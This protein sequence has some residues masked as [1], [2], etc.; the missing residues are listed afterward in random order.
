MVDSATNICC[1]YPIVT[2]KLE[3]NTIYWK[4]VGEQCFVAIYLLIVQYQ[5][6]KSSSTIVSVPMAIDLSRSVADDKKT[7]DV[8][9]EHMSKDTTL[10]KRFLSLCQFC[11]TVAI[12]LTH[13]HHA[14]IFHIALSVNQG[15]LQ[16][17]LFNWPPLISVPKRK[18][19][20]SRSQLLFQ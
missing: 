20:S 12:V 3:A 10:I 5:E 11:H 14:D 2:L 17:D 6:D 8:V 7:T 15:K 16:G 13:I 4:C 1:C 19:R 9:E 18:P